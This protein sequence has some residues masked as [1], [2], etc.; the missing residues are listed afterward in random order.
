MARR[1]SAAAGGKP[2]S[3]VAGVWRQVIAKVEEW[4][5]GATQLYYAAFIPATIA[6]GMCLT[7]PRPAVVSLLSPM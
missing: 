3:G 6:V 4:T 1:R 5:P 7:T 2:G